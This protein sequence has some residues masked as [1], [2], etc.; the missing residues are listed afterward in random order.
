MIFVAHSLGGLILQ[1][2]LIRCS[3]SLLKSIHGVIF[4]ATPNHGL[5][6]ENW[7]KYFTSVS[8]VLGRQPLVKPSTFQ[9]M[10]ELTEKFLNFLKRQHQQ[11]FTRKVVC[12]Y[13]TEPVTR[14]GIVVGQA[15]SCVCI[16]Y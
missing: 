14:N 4:F 1:A 7:A 3:D 11:A 16:T 6:E 9:Y 2:F 15:V 5:H 13:E 12:L 8:L 10:R